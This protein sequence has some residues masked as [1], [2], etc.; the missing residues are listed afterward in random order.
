[1]AI[2]E[3]RE[4]GFEAK[5]AHDEELLFKIMARRNEMLGQWAAAELGLG[6]SDSEAYAE[7]LIRAGLLGQGADP[8]IERIR[9]DFSAKNIQIS[10]HM[11]ERKVEEFHNAAR[12][13]LAPS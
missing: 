3:E 8:A 4:I 7:A 5:W 11:I 10:N 13:Q 1:M 12:Q 2:F 9:R 6:K